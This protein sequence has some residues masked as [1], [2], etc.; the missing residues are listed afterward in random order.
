MQDI[1]RLCDK[2]SHLRTHKRAQGNDGRQ[3]NRTYTLSPADLCASQESHQPRKNSF[4]HTQKT[5]TLVHMDEGSQRGSGGQ[6]NPSSLRGR[7]LL[8]L[9]SPYPSCARRAHHGLGD[10]HPLCQWRGSL[11]CL[12]DGRVCCLHGCGTHHGMQGKNILGL[13]RQC[14]MF[15]EEIN[16]GK[17]R[18]Q[19]ALGRNRC[20]RIEG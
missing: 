17:G 15:V 10:I 5:H 19:G 16:V 11:E 18:G 2:K 7:E 12:A 14:G 8:P 20:G 9:P 1:V 3:G 13:H 4:Q 6:G